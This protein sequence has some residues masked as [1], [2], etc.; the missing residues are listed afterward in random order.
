M[1]AHR[2]VQEAQRRRGRRFPAP[3]ARVEP[4]TE[5]LFGTVNALVLNLR[6]RPSTAKPPI[7]QLRRG[8]QVEV[9]DRLGSWYRI[10]AG[11]VAGYV[12]RRFITLL[13]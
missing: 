12:S 7:L 10:Q 13:R 2:A 5:L 1:N 8:M 6:P 11:S 4:S 3:A 9:L